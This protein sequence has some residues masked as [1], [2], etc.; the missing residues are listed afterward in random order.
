M[1]PIKE[2][3]MM[4]KAKTLCGI[5]VAAV[6]GVASILPASAGPMFSNASGISQASRD[7]IVDVRWR[8]HRGAGIAAGVAAGALFGAAIANSTY[9]YGP[10]YYGYGYAPSYS[11]GYGPSYYEPYGA[12]AYAPSYPYRRQYYYETP[13]GPP[14]YGW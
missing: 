10:G 9:A 11:Y 1:G 12:Y 3:V 6:V 4:T 14:S 7:N 13:V 2:A 8:G 5:G